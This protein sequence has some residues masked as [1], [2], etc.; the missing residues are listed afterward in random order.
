MVL[1]SGENY[2]FACSGISKELRTARE[3]PPVA[4]RRA[5]TYQELEMSD[6]SQILPLHL[7]QQ[8]DDSDIPFSDEESDCSATSGDSEQLHQL[9]DDM[10]GEIGEIPN[11]NLN[12]N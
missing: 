11:N 9:G 6:L 2:V 8:N 3:S 5:D 4:F 10:L 7:Q 12:Q 1:L